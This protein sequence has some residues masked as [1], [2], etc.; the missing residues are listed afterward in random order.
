MGRTYAG[1]LGLTAFTIA[2]ARGLLGG[3]SLDGTLWMASGCLFVF[4]AI[5]FVAGQIAASIVSDSVRAKF[6]AELQATEPSGNRR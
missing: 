4:A 3:G 2:V 1:I 5:G 6:A